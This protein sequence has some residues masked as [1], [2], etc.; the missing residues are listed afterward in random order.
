MKEK[1]FIS[2]VVYLYNNANYATTFL[3]M[4]YQTLDCKFEK[5]EIICVNDASSD[6]TKEAIKNCKQRMGNCVLTIV[7]MSFHQGLEAS[8]NA[9]IDLAIGD[10][11][12][13][14]DSGTLDFTGETILAAYD[15]SLT[16]FD[17]V[18]AKSGEGKFTSKMFYKLFNRNSNT[19][20]DLST[21]SFRLVSRRA[22]NR[23]YSLSSTRPYRKAQ[24]YSCGLLAAVIDYKR[25]AETVK[26][27]SGKKGD[28]ALN[29]IILF[30]NVAYKVSIAFAIAMMLV[31]VATA[32]YVFA[33]FLVGR[34][35][36]GYTT[37]MFV[38]T[39]GFFGVFAILAIIIKYLS[40]IVDLIFKKQKY[41]VESIEKITG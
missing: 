26:V 2:A 27:S 21:E 19:Q 9:G 34:P 31:T 4:L 36:E 23:V 8:M 20:Y 15:K 37:T 11:V 10:F 33:V 41:I 7:N 3:P 17:I 16:G 14:F 5:F 38:I 35:V 1:N 22:I 24:Y 18:A 25:V 29:S 12:Y 13:E 30:T 32:V 39:G 40:V 28:L 6:N